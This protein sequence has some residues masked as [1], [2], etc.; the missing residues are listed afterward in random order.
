MKKTNLKLLLLAFFLVAL[1]TL[2]GCNGSNTGSPIT[3]QEI[4]VGTDGLTAGFLNV[5]DEVFEGDPFRVNIEI[6]NKGAYPAREEIDD[7]EAF[8]SLSI[9][10]DYMKIGNWFKNEWLK[11]TEINVISNELI[12]FTLKGK[13]MDNPLGDKGFLSADINV[14]KIKEE[15]SETHNSDIIANL[16][17]KYQTKAVPTVCIDAQQ[18]SY[19]QKEKSCT[20]KDI[21]FSSQGAPIAVTKIESEMLPLGSTMVKPMF[22]IYLED[23]GNGDAISIFRED[24]EQIADNIDAL[25]NSCTSASIGHGDLNYVLV[26]VKM[27]NRVL[28]CSPRYGLV[29]IKDKQGMVRCTLNEGISEER[30]TYTTPLQIIIDYG[31]MFSITKRVRIKKILTY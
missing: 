28:E 20:I 2:T 14:E 22:T 15:Q 29:R 11:E 26:S 10:E 9:E 19:K 31:Y 23:K 1:L 8:L 5:P 27:G 12:S 25:E 16:C 6:E 21:T 30:G 3:S 24:G 17:Y 4:Y 7:F 13:T 18:Y